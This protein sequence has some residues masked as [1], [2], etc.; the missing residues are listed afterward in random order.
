MPDW[1]SVHVRCPFYHKE[2]PDRIVCEGVC[3]GT[4]SNTTL[5]ENKIRK[6]EYEKVYC[7]TGY[8]R[9]EIFKAIDKKYN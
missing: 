8:D 9:C 2:F 7:E 3:E 6:N 5:F 1:K 4:L